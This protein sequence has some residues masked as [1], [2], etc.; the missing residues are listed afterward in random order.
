MTNRE[1]L[2]HLFLDVFLLGPDEFNFDLR[3]DQVETW[4]SLGVVSLA[5]GIQEAFGYHLTPEEALRI[6][7]V[8]DII[9]ILTARGIPFDA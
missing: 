9:D 2:R 5:V 6:R 1:K 4:D 3:R 7:E 8:Q